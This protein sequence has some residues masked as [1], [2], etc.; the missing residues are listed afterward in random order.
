MIATGGCSVR[1]AGG[2]KSRRRQ[3]SV[4]THPTL[5]ESA[6]LPPGLPAMRRRRFDFYGT[7]VEFCGITLKKVVRGGCIQLNFP[8][9]DATLPAGA[10][11]ERSEW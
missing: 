9:S 8:A 7:A 4:L 5:P 11:F 3:R 1:Q 10:D 2:G 6:D